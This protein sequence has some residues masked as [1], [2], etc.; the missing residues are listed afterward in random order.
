MMAWTIV[1]VCVILMHE[2]FCLAPTIDASDPS[3]KRCLEAAKAIVASV[4]ELSGTYRREITRTCWL[5][6]RALRAG[7]SFETGLLYSFLN[8]LWAVAGRECLWMRAEQNSDLSN[9]SAYFRHACPRPRACFAPRRPHLGI[10]TCTGCAS[11]HYGDARKSLPGRHGHGTQFAAPPRK[12]FPGPQRGLH[13][14]WRLPACRRQCRTRW[15][16]RRRTSRFEKQRHGDA[17]GSRRDGR[18][19]P[20]DSQRSCRRFVGLR[21]GYRGQRRFLPVRH[22]ASRRFHPKTRSVT[23]SCSHSAMM[24]GSPLASRV[25]ITPKSPPLAFEPTLTTCWIPCFAFG[26]SGLT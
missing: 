8:W 10:A 26:S 16:Q 14:L 25:E 11:A 7:S 15:R 20:S 4:H 24:T 19:G 22:R 21:D 5:L 6:T 1:H 9:V 17:C 13:R 23:T 2:P 12:P 3:F 18:T